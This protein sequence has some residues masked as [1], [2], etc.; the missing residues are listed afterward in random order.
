[1]AVGS[2]VR[3][4]VW[5]IHHR[6]DPR[7]HYVISQNAPVR[8]NHEA[9]GPRVVHDATSRCILVFNLDGRDAVLQEESP[10]LQMTA[11]MG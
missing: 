4:P 8:E 5:Q 3:G 9:L 2:L 6:D 7:K 11:K 1:M 10:S